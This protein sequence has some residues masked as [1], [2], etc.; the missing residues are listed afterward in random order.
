MAVTSPFTLQEAVSLGHMF[1]ALEI[2]NWGNL[3]TGADA[4]SLVYTGSITHTAGMIAVG[5]ESTVDQAVVTYTPP[6]FVGKTPITPN[7]FVGLECP[8][9]VLP[10]PITVGAGLTPLFADTYLR[11]GNA[12]PQAFGGAEP[13][14]E[15]PF[16]QLM[17]YLQA[18]GVNGQFPATRRGTMIRRVAPVVPNAGTTET[19]LGIWPVMG[20]S[21]LAVYFGA[22]GNLVADVRVGVIPGEYA[23]GEPPAEET[24]GTGTVNATTGANAAVFPTQSCAFLAAY[25]TRTSGTGA[26]R[27]KVVASD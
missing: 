3:G 2:T 4:N 19:L 1:W 22:A 10:A 21:K 24:A 25:Y 14:F 9:I 12:T 27:V 17:F 26:L 7:T 16:L 23:L 11:D 13:L 6:Q 5:A 18:P 8:G 15:A 20:R